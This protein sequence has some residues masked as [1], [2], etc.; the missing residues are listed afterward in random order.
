MP[1]G[2]HIY[3]KEY[4]MARAK[5]CVYPQLDHTLPHW[6]CVFQCCTKFPRVNLPDQE[7]DYQYSDTSN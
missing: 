2:R 5:M 6:K 4:D 7:T 1:H 3:A